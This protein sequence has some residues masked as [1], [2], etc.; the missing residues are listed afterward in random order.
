[1]FG[2]VCVSDN[3]RRVWTCV[4][5]REWNHRADDPQ[6]SYPEANESIFSLPSI[7]VPSPSRW[8]RQSN[9][10][11][12]HQK[13]KEKYST[14]SQSRHFSKW[15]G[16]AERLYITQ[17]ISYLA[18]GV[19]RCSG[20]RG[21]THWIRGSRADYG[22]I[23]GDGPAL[24]DKRGWC[25]WWRWPP[26]IHQAWRCHL[27]PSLLRLRRADGWLRWRHEDIWGAWHY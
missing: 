4:A 2:Q 10:S 18:L 16:G 1:M 24:P 8:T 7:A 26:S 20:F 13:S 21:L 6:L 23:C 11:K 3:S 27:S 19:N 9:Q 25:C 5:P 22:Q 12:S 14:C 17:T 15:G